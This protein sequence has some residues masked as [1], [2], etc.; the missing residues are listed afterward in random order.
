VHAERTVRAA[1]DLA[2]AGANAPDIARQLGIS[3]RTVSDW[4]R[5]QVP[6]TPRCAPGGMADHD[7]AALPAAY[8]YLLGLYLGD[9]S[10]ATHPR[11]LY[12]LRVSLDLRYPGIIEQYVEAIAEVAPRNRIGRCSHG[13]WVEVN[14]Y[15]KAGPCL[16]PQH[17]RGKKHERRIVLAEWQEALVDRWPQHLVRGL[18]H[19]DG[20]RFQNTGR[21]NWSCPRYSFTKHSRDIRA[22]FCRAC[23]AIQVHWTSAG[24][25]TIHVSRKADVARLD[26]FIGPKR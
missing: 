24:P 20:C 6:H 4:I 26:E 14:C 22:I 3:R 23:E 11:G 17:G 12:R 16:F 15:S 10:I 19:S 2:A 25:N 8:V 9:G 7:F 13:T 21:C 18:I 5:A 1:L